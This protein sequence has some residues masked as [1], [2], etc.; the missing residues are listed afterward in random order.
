MSGARADTALPEIVSATSESTRAYFSL[1]SS[2]VCTTAPPACLRIV[3][4]FCMLFMPMS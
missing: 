4:Q 2:R 3:S 1:L